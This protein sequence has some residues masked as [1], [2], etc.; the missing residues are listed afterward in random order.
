MSERGT[1]KVRLHSAK[2]RR[3]SSTRW[4]TRQLND[5]Y[6]QRA[7]KEGYRSRA[8]YKLIEIDRKLGLLKPGRRVFD[9]GSAPGGWLQ[10][11]ARRGCRVVGV[12]LVEVAPVA[13]AMLLE[14]DIFDAAMPAR[15]IEAMGGPADV[16]LSDLAAASI[17]QRS[18]DRL[19]AES[20][21]ETV[22]SLLPLLLAPGGSLV[23]KLVRGA[24]TAI[25]GAARRLFDRAQLVRPKA[26]R[27][28]SSEIY[29]VGTGYRGPT[30]A[31]A[32][33]DQAASR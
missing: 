10:V 15:L 20:L 11:A 19:R 14:G 29:L 27:P 28:E 5:P 8:A 30:T 9:L 3:L 13:D 32:V 2:G 18:V 6:V 17:G 7:R 22:L 26:T 4:L 1:G 12:D 24:D 16:L 23:V 25:A 33:P 21:G 31:D